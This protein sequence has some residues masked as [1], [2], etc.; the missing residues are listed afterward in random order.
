[1]AITYLEP[2]PDLK[3]EAAR[4]FNKKADENAHKKYELSPEEKKFIQE[5]RKHSGY[6]SK[7]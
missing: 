5:V 4:E 2:I 6:Y 1:M 3:G 7:D